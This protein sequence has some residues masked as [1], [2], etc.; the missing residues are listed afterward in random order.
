M[1]PSQSFTGGAEPS[2]Y[3]SLIAYPVIAFLLGWFTIKK[4]REG[5]VAKVAK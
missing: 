2:F 4:M 3:L 5:A 1:G